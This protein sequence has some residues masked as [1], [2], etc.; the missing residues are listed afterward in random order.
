MKKD[1]GLASRAWWRAATLLLFA[2]Q[3]L[4]QDDKKDFS[5]TNAVAIVFG[6]SEIGTR[7]SG[8][9]LEHRSYSSD[10]ITKPE[11]VQGVSCRSLHLTERGVPKGYFFFTI[12]P[13]FKNRDISRVKIEV[14]YFDG[15]DLLGTVFGVQ[16]DAKGS[17]ENRALTVKQILP[18][19][20][21]RGSGQW[22]KATFH[23]PDA[24]FANS[25]S[26]KSDFRIWA[27]P[28]ELS[29]SR[30]TLTLESSESV[31]NAPLKFDGAG[32]A[33]LRDW[34]LQWDTGVKPSF[35]VRET[36]DGEPATLVIRAP[37]AVSVGSWRSAAFLEPGLYQFVGKA[38]LEGFDPAAEEER[39]GIALRISGRYVPS[40]VTAAPDWTIIQYDFTLA[41]AD[42]VELVCELRATQGTARFDRDS[43]R[44]LRRKL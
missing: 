28:P 43:L 26:H 2:S 29:L 24:K 20:V 9:G 33:R 15:L 12:D 44:I 22:L 3:A 25:Q 13:S 38:K 35:S 16:Y 5:R 32:E 17:D 42:W 31:A 8:N 41:D 30:V 14:D 1:A 39:S 23:L 6:E 34:N 36:K 11:N 21:L 19:I 10:G 18:N 37:D 4:A 7:V 40:M 27:S